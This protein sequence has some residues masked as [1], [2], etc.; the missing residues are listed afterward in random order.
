MNKELL[1]RRHSVNG[2]R[3]R[4]ANSELQTVAQYSTV[5]I[6]LSQRRP[7]LLAEPT[8]RRTRTYPRNR[9]ELQS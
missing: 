2:I 3:S 6:D 7:E 5:T 4:I 9:R 1:K 8:A